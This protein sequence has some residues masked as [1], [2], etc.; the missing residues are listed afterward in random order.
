MKTS[1]FPQWL[2]RHC[3]Q[4]VDDLM[5]PTWRVMFPLQMDRWTGNSSRSRSADNGENLRMCPPLATG[6]PQ[7]GLSSSWSLIIFT[8]KRA[9]QATVQVD[10]LGESDL[11]RSVQVN[12]DRVGPSNLVTI[13]W[14]IPGMPN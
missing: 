6:Q 10:S 8:V 9:G 1:K 13:V 3:T 11:E 7:D 4:L 14:P 5:G 12:M 2:L